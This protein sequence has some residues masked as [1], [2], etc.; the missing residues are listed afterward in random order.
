ME[1]SRIGL[2]STERQVGATEQP[3]LDDIRTALV[4]VY[5]TDFGI[6]ESTW[7]RA[8]PTWHGRTR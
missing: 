5:G 4:D 8:S 7:I 2:V 1:D 6:H 3:T